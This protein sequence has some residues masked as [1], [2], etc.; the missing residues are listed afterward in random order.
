MI[1]IDSNVF[2]YA[3]L[4]L[5]SEDNAKFSKDILK[6]IFD[7]Q[8]MAATSTLTWDEVVWTIKRL[9]GPETALDEG[10]K[11]LEFP[12]IKFL[13]VGEKELRSALRLM[14]EYNIDPRDSIHAAC[15]IENNIKEII[16]NDSDFYKIGEIH[17][18][19]LNKIA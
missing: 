17:V 10:Q 6:S 15:C 7:G 3:A 2:I 16:T 1:Y 5:D 4:S 19:P 11:F 12:K 18:I 9:A 14:K 13:K 8:I